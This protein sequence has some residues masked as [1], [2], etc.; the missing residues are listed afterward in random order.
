MLRDPGL[1][2]TELYGGELPSFEELHRKHP[3]FFRSGKR[4][5]WREHFDAELQEQFWNN[6]REQMERLGYS[7]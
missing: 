4:G 6:H 5:D 2:P 1:R 3:Q 7:R